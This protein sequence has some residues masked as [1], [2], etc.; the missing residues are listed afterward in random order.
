MSCATKPHTEKRLSELVKGD[1]I[2][3]TGQ[4][5]AVIAKVV[6]VNG[7][8]RITYHQKGSTKNWLSNRDGLVKVHTT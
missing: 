6:N 2:C 1:A 5:S 7:L 8:L 4:R 3:L